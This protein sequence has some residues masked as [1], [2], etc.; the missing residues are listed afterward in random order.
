MDLP[1]MSCVV[2]LGVL[3]GCLLGGVAPQLSP[4]P[5]TPPSWPCSFQGEESDLGV[6]QT[7]VALSV[8]V[9]GNPLFYVPGTWYQVSLTSSSM[10]NGISVIGVF[11]SQ[12]PGTSVGPW[13]ASSPIPGITYMCSLIHQQMMRLP[14]RDA[15]LYWIAP[16]AGSGCVSFMVTAFLGQQTILKDA[17]ALQL[18]ERGMPTSAPFRP[19][20][21]SVHSDGVILRD[22]FDSSD[23]LDYTVWSELHGG[24]ISDSCG[25]VLH[26][27]SIVFCNHLGRRELSTAHLNLTSASVL[28][29]ALSSGVCKPGVGD[30]SLSVSYAVNDRVDWHQI[31]KIRVPTDGHT[32]IHIIH[33]PT[34]ARQP[35]VCLRLHQD[36]A[37]DVHS[38]YGC[39]ALD[40]VLIT[41]MAHRPTALEEEFDPIAM[42]NWLFF[43]GG[44][45]R[46]ACHSEGDALFFH[47]PAQPDQ[48]IY[49][50]VTTHDL[51]LY[52]P[53]SSLILEEHIHGDRMPA[54]WN[55]T[56]G[57][58]G[59]MCGTVHSGSSLVFSGDGDRLA[60]S[61]YINAT[62]AGNMRFH[63]TMG[64]GSCDPADTEDVQVEVLAQVDGMQAPILLTTLAYNSYRKPQPV[65]VNIPP[66]AR[67][68]ATK[69]CLQ[70]RI[71]HGLNRNVWAVDEILISSWRP[72]RIIHHLQF[73]LSLA[74]GSDE[75][76]ASDGSWVHVEFSTDR[77][78]SW[79]MLRE[80]CHP[81]TCQGSVIAE[82]SV[83][84][85]QDVHEGWTRVILPLPSAALTSSTR[86]RWR[87]ALPTPQTK[88]AIDNVYIGDACSD[89][90]CTG[91]GR[92][93]AQ[94]CRCDTDFTSHDCSIPVS[95]L[96]TNFTEDF[97]DFDAETDFK[98]ST[99]RGGIVGYD[100]GVLASGKAL[101][102]NQDGRREIVT[103]ELNSTNSRFLQFTVRIG[104]HSSIGTCASPDDQ[105]E[106]LLLFYSCNNG[107]EWQLL[108]HME[109]NGYKTPRSELIHLP[110]GAMGPACR[111]RW[112]QPSHS[113]T[114]RDVWALDGIS[115]T[116]VLYNTIK[117]DMSDERTVG[118]ALSFHLGEIRDFC[119]AQKALVFSG[120]SEP[121]G[122]RYAETQ[123]LRIGASYIVQFDL[124]MGCGRRYNQPHRDDKKVYLEFSTDHGLS[125]Q[126]VTQECL[127]GQTHCQDDYH[128]ASVYDDTQYGD[129][130]R[131]TVRLPSA[132][133]TASTRIR[134]RQS[135][136]TGM[137][138][139]A[140]DNIYIG[141]ECPKL[142]H[143]H[144]RCVDGECRC[145][146]TRYSGETCT[147]SY[148][149]SSVQSDFNEAAVLFS[150][151]RDVH[152]GMIT[153]GEDGCGIVT[154]GS[155]L[156]FYGPG[157][158]DIV[159]HDLNTA[160][161]SFI[162]FY[163]R[164]GGDGTQASCRGIDRR[165]EGVLLQYSNDGG[166]TWQLLLE[167]YY[168]DYRQA[169]FVHQKLPP[170]AKTGCT[171]FRWWQ[172]THAGAFEDQWA[173]DDVYI[174]NEFNTQ[175]GHDT[176]IQDKGISPDGLWMTISNGEPGSYCSS[177][178]MNALVFNQLGGDRFAVT[179]KMALKPGDVIQ[180]KIVIGCLSGFTHFA[181]VYLQYSHDNGLHWNQV[182]DNCY[183]SSMEEG[184]C[185]GAGL[186]YQEGSVYHMGQYAYWR[187]VVIRLPEYITQKK[188]QF[189]F[190]QAEDKF[191]PTFSIGEVYVGE[192]CPENCHGHGVCRDGECHCDYG[193]TGTSCQPLRE[194]SMGLKD[195]FE[196]RT[197][198]ALWASIQSGAIGQGCGII[199][200]DNTLYFG[201]VGPREARTVPLNTTAIKILQFFLRIG[202][203]HL[204][205]QCTQATSRRETVI[206]QFSVDNSIT[207]HTLQAIDPTA[208]DMASSIKITV[209]LPAAAKTD[210]TVFRWWQPFISMDVRQ[211]QWAID[212][213]LIGANDT[214]AQG[215]YEP[216]DMELSDNWYSV[217]A[218]TQKTYCQS[219][220]EALVFDGRSGI[221]RYA[222]TWDF[223][224]TPATFLQFEIVA[225]CGQSAFSSPN[226]SIVLEYSVDMGRSW[227]VLKEECVPPDMGC[228]GYDLGS[229]YTADMYS[230][231]TRVTVYLPKAA[232]SPSTRFRWSQPVF[233]G[234]Q[235]VWALDSIHLGLYDCPWMCSGHGGCQNGQCICDQGYGGSRCVP[236]QPLPKMLKDNFEGLLSEERWPSSYGVDI[237]N[238]C[239]ILLSGTAAVFRQAGP[240][241]LVTQDLDCTMMQYMQ[242]TFQYSCP[243]QG[244]GVDP[245]RSRAVLVQYSSNGGTTWETLQ[246]LHYTAP[247][248]PTFINIKLP[249]FQNNATKF[250]FWQPKHS[251]DSDSWAIDGLI[252][253]GNLMGSNMLA[254][255]F[256][257]G[258]SEVDWLYYPGAR[259][260]RF[261]PPSDDVD[262][263]STQPRLAAGSSL[264]LVYQLQ[265]GEHSM[266]TRDIDVNE[267]TMV[268]FEINVGCTAETISA[269]P[270]SLEYSRDHGSTWNL[271][272]PD[273]FNQNWS[274]SVCSGHVSEPSVYYIG[275]IE[276]WKRVTILINGLH[277][278]GIAR[279]RWYQGFYRS[280]DQPRPW[281]LDN[282]YIGPLCP[283]LCGG[284][285][286]CMDGNQCRCDRGYGGR[287]CYAIQQNPRYLKE[288]FEDSKVDSM[289]FLQW[290][291]GEVTSKC[292]TLI[293]GTSLHF[294]GSGKRMLVTRDLNLT[295]ASIV[296]FFIRLGC[297][298]TPPS[299]KNHPIQ[300]QYSTNAGI[301]WSLLEEMHFSNI[302]NQARY[303]MLELPSGSRSNATRIRWWQPSN[304]GSFLDE[305]AIDQIFIG[306]HGHPMLQDDFDS[307][308]QRDS[309]EI[310]SPHD[311]NW[312]LSPGGVTE[313]VCDSGV[314][315]L[316]F[317]SNDQMRYMVSTDVMVTEQTFLQFELTMGCTRSNQCYSID[318]EYSLDMGK[319]W[320][321]V[322]Q[323]CLPSDI[324]CSHYHPSSQ[325]GADIYAGWNR[326]IMP[327]PPHTRSKSTQ[328][329]WRQPDGF[330]PS[331]TWAVSYVY[332]G[333]E[334]TT[335]CTGHG[336]CNTAYCVCDSN[337]Q[338]PAC[339]F[340][341]RPLPQQV[342]EPF[343]QQP[344][345]SGGGAWLNING[346]MVSSSCGPVASGKA[347]HFTGACT[348]QLITTDLDLTHGT[349]IQFYIRYGCLSLPT[350][351]SHNVLLQYSTDGGVH[352]A[353][354]TELHYSRY[355]IPSFVSIE[356]PT[357]A[358]T[359]G[360]RFSWW[361]PNHPGI[362]QADWAID[363][364]LIGGSSD[365]R[366]S[367]MADDFDLGLP[368][369][370]W[371]FL[372]NAAVLPF[373]D[374]LDQ[375]GMLDGMRENLSL[376]G[377]LDAEEGTVI[378]TVD[379][380]LQEGT[381][382]EFE[383][384]T[385][386]NASW[387]SPFSPV[388]L[389]FSTDHGI[390]WSHL[391]R[392]CLPSDPECNG[393]VTP[394]SSY[395]VH[396]GWRRVVIPLP[397]EAISGSTRFR[398]YQ[399]VL[400]GSLPQRWALD[401]VS[402]GPACPLMC[403]GHGSCDYPQCICDEGF[404]GFACERSLGIRDNLKESFLSS[405]L[406]SSAWD[407]VQG[408]RITTTQDC[409]TVREGWSL[410]LSGLG[411]RLA[412]TMDLDLRD[413]SF[414]QYHAVIGSE[415]NIPSCIRPAGRSESVLLQ[416]S[417]DGGISW[418]LLAEL[419]YERYT[420][421]QRHYFTLPAAARTQATRLRWW[422]PVG[423]GR[424]AQWALDDVYIGGSEI[425]PTHL[426][427]SFNV[428]LTEALW[429]FY[430]YG[431]VRVGVCLNSESAL[432]WANRRYSQEDNVAVTRQLIIDANYMLQF[433]IVVGC[434]DVSPS[435]IEDFPVSLEYK[436]HPAD[437]HWTLL[438]PTCLPDSDDD[439]RCYPMQYE[440]G[441]VYS[442]NE[443]GVWRR[444]MYALPP[445]TVS[446]MTQFRWIQVSAS[447]PAPAWSLDDVYIGASCPDLCSGHGSCGSDGRCQ[448]DPGF[449][450]EKCI[451]KRPLPIRLDDSFEGGISDRT[452]SSVRGGGLGM[453]CGALVP[454]AHG[455][456][457]Y[458][459]Q[460]GLREAITVE[461]DTTRAREIMFVLQIGSASLTNP[462]CF[463]NLTSPDIENKAVLL[464][465]TTDNGIHWHL[466]ESHDPAD[467][468][469]AQRVSYRLPAEAGG[470]AVR[471]R[472]WQPRHG[473]S[474]RDQWAID[475]VQLVMSRHVMLNP[476]YK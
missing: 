34:E 363:N 438:K 3:L 413:A 186:T 334:C 105:S 458:F 132:L 310:T 232:V 142:C 237:G 318:L 190:W 117:V 163:I 162:Q 75:V 389:I 476:Y 45:I 329:R 221:P 12:I 300:L 469:R 342:R 250:R 223:E 364:I 282:V 92:C 256:D 452:W 298:R 111:F 73:G 392:Q 234:Q 337:W 175:A 91:H 201:S 49:Q 427:E 106:S 407:L 353:L 126:L 222:E 78:R 213:V 52:M 385:G 414:V 33:L 323:E 305:W 338:G 139:W 394:P 418:I 372:D 262:V 48:D 404:D 322:Y 177:V 296:H 114:G 47:T 240:R 108:K 218:G 39:W 61:Q 25:T 191:A 448:C 42:D 122:I 180:F 10:F 425:N 474:G 379:L 275:E 361:Q 378:T 20:L 336:R 409:G 57:H 36:L 317:G 450:G 386:C 316:H 19:Q 362:N 185:T 309:N 56:G 152:G 43:P 100:C 192:A 53:A 260:D 129:W 2:V 170:S 290:S 332:I 315:A 146:G 167:L 429:D 228:G 71:H 410:Y 286:A 244:T 259:L 400:P 473:G 159:S 88:W 124:V 326:V 285:G 345:V 432:Y 258:V 120:S 459:S 248:S 215:F 199:K 391:I 149:P 96:P 21:A 272:K 435:C 137:D 62:E 102:F 64:G 95:P 187:L 65:S 173:L 328:F 84:G 54:N 150:D 226:H 365:N 347:L 306:G 40:N 439:A 264:G 278:C 127:P 475:H 195:E 295:A 29:F 158:R 269:F 63:F 380:Q 245:D 263:Q 14:Q 330:E 76:H 183:P 461:L 433:K 416:Y 37:M 169:K 314:N 344:V 424:R 377:G 273:C 138:S 366:P 331:S 349:H 208:V 408:G 115:L 4:Y 130:S 313:Q 348:R 241:M 472:W 41:S 182:V 204:G 94:G 155:S 181:P 356:L 279:F 441:S 249:M 35:G 60:C 419:D 454:H 235:D 121:G 335:M 467:Y 196:G 463:L 164:L 90:M 171:R 83:Y 343:S 197:L 288:E 320:Q 354:L 229:I 38:F 16:P 324:D 118:Q 246:E 304:Q 443:Y 412:E 321:L 93:T 297:Q 319:H 453:G 251:G 247:L 67:S 415:R 238:M 233:T 395:Y 216:F 371:L 9:E 214:H 225:G 387:D 431:Q 274:S 401:D 445:K 440:R 284:H 293:T 254:G 227:H 231:W 302:S 154:S 428:G 340:P 287:N 444:V 113:G 193:Y 1:G 58:V 179:R 119:K 325:L 312:I 203:T 423:N 373:C 81:D 261:C 384:S 457:L 266:T 403:S 74:C 110:S 422:Q 168:T 133:R 271:L 355:S 157:V 172:P 5:F 230:Q 46:S 44:H 166:I 430:P 85:L 176:Y 161:A 437:S 206:V 376:V 141:R 99:L 31:E 307:S 202:S 156:Y 396:H 393:V 11:T 109:Y 207:W 112:W 178:N 77:G 184:M 253:G 135:V 252:I 98:F 464:Q 447:H 101:V 59:Q 143:G 15:L 303:V 442:A 460:C 165:A 421:P 160:S 220:Q 72:D 209:E 455:K 24:N 462:S 341:I 411:L 350:Q 405:D 383:I 69:F 148:L 243:S 388:Q 270:V 471:F 382:L 79:S 367:A 465:Y 333:S 145:D 205:S 299:N 80:Q 26:G 374:E 294:V 153:G 268:Q 8:S 417:I 27:D 128:G 466:I 346:G 70:Q 280:H 134:W 456:S 28:Q 239:G 402:I 308:M 358:R 17:L 82:S 140:I 236:L 18:C 30:Y 194:N 104:S 212:N 357:T 289:K 103:E 147:P 200:M 242:F 116:S 22:D 255:D 301:T 390:T 451:P 267:H 198:G 189:R 375:E 174:G 265:P 470:R 352:W 283:E 434:Q 51:N 291:G 123:S 50:F 449:I 339:E 13:D 360:T 351:R 210:D 446:S 359:V 399:E 87:Q 468:Q 224:I 7:E 311:Q 327:L 97:E 398:W 381:V 66:S 292:G 68:P 144:G 426:T 86:F 6:G 436:T 217:M 370:D 211:A 277:I 219:R 257:S 23:A 406:D 151:W 276:P 397:E 281:A 55:I 125:W 32:T 188:A 131:I 136:F 107:I 420:T 369:I 368:S 89:H